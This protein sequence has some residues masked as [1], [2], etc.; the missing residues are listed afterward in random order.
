MVFSALKM[1]PERAVRGSDEKNFF[2]IR[3]RHEK[4]CPKQQSPVDS[5]ETSS[6]WVRFSEKNVE[7]VEK[8]AIF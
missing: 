8:S 7:K 4:L 6:S 3:I 2:D 5:V 1:G